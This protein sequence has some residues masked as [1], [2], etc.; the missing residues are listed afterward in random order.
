[1]L[2]RIIFAICLTTTLF[3]FSQEWEEFAADFS[4]NDWGWPE[5]VWS[6]KTAKIEDGVYKI[7]NLHTEENGCFLTGVI[8]RDYDYIFEA[9]I[10]QVEGPTNRG[11]GLVLGWDSWESYATAQISTE[12]Y[13]KI[14]EWKFNKRTM[15]VKPFKHEGGAI[16][17]DGAW[18][19]LRLERKNGKTGFYVNDVKV[20][21]IDGFMFWGSKLG[22]I[23]DKGQAI[24]VD[25]MKVKRV[26]LSIDEVPHAVLEDS[27]TNLGENVNSTASDLVPIISSDGK[28]LYYSIQGSKELNL[29]EDQELDVFMAEIG[30][31]G[32]FKERVRLPAPI[33]NEEHNSMISIS[34]DENSALFLNSYNEDGT[35]SGGISYGIKRDGKWL[36][37]EKVKINDY[38]N[39]AKKTEYCLSAD[40]LVLLSSADTGEGYGINDINVSFL[41]EDGSWSK[42]KNLGP[43]INTYHKEISPFL[44]ADG[45]TL[46]FSSYGHPGYGK[47][48]IFVSKRLDDTWQNWTKPKNVG[49]II[50]SKGFDAYFKIDAQGI[51]AYL[52]SAKEGTIGRSDIWRIKVGEGLRPEALN[53]VI[54]KVFNA[55]TNKEIEAAIEYEDLTDGKRLGVAYSTT[56]NGY[57]ITLPKGK[58]YG[59]RASADGFI[60]VAQN[61]DLTDITKYDEKTVNLYLVP[62]KKGQKLTLN[63][64]FFDSGKSTLKKESFS[65]L[66]RLADIMKKNPE[67]KIEISGHTDSDGDASKNKVLSQDRAKAVLQYLISKG[68]NKSNMTSIGYG[69]SQPV[70]DNNTDE[71]KKQNRR[72]EM[73]IL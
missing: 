35:M 69:E 63:N 70:A 47:A 36:R 53:L 52:S 60:S 51:Y 33:N 21:E 17:G 50:N 41:Q 38:K 19:V 67:M 59:F 20:A 13:V 61:L 32:E 22:F 65:E 14:E 58:K 8:N 73:K 10:K 11:F 25:E 16:K 37:P 1:M 64:L 12:G 56:E 57:K 31:N 15:H 27:L 30:E 45:K 54:G 7:K 9:K 62:I 34:P 72:V 3:S 68:V 40:G 5:D 6:H 18:N 24:E 71:G 29:G 46:F 66:N 28:R 23:M 48:D 26:K 44:A 42:P 39:L 4:K 49:P 2:K 43:T 55:E